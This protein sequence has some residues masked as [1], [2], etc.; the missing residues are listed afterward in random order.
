MAQTTTTSVVVE[1]MAEHLLAMEEEGKEEME[2]VP[3]P[4]TERQGEAEFQAAREVQEV[5]ATVLGNLER[6]G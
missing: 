1:E 6:T 4:M 3:V 2:E 5:M